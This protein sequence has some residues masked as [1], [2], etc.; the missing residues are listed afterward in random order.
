MAPEE[1]GPIA[2]LENLLAGAFGF[3]R[4]D[5]R[6]RAELA[7]RMHQRPIG[8]FTSATCGMAAG[9]ATITTTQIPVLRWIA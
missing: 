6:I 7:R 2:S 4:Q 9:S 3:E 1:F 8:L 5:V